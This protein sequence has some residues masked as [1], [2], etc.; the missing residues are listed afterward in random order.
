MLI[1]SFIRKE[2]QNIRGR[3]VYVS[4]LLFSTSAVNAVKLSPLLGH[5]ERNQPSDKQAQKP[6]AS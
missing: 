3:G 6:L 4:S 2:R 5:N 1:I